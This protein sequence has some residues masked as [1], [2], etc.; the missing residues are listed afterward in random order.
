VVYDNY[1]NEMFLLFDEEI[2][3]GELVP[4]ERDSVPHSAVLHSE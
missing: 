4:L 1:N 3:F 2:T